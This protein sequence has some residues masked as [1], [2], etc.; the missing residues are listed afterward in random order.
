M[1]APQPRDFKRLQR[2]AQ[3]DLTGTR[4]NARGDGQTKGNKRKDATNVRAS[5][6][7]GNPVVESSAQQAA[8]PNNDQEAVGE[9]GPLTSSPKKL[10]KLDLADH[11]RNSVQYYGFEFT[12]TPYIPLFI[13]REV[14]NRGRMSPSLSVIRSLQASS[15]DFATAIKETCEWIHDHRHAILAYDPIGSQIVGEA[16]WKA[17]T[18]LEDSYEQTVVMPQGALKLILHTCLTG[19]HWVYRFVNPGHKEIDKQDDAWALDEWKLKALRRQ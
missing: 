7:I 5:E 9:L 16:Y 17:C 2:K 19:A 13:A 3:V 1:S 11:P 4:G 8:H 12:D 15:E 18:V 14:I 10:L 6:A